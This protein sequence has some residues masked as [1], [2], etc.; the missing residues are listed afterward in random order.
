MNTQNE[1]SSNV[2]REHKDRLFKFIFGKP[3]NKKW[4]LSLYNAVN[5]SSYEN[6][7]D[8]VYTTIEDAVY[9]NMKN[10]VSFLI[11]DEMNFYEQQSTFNPNMPMR[12]FIYAGMVYSKYIESSKEY[13]KYSSKLQKAPTPKCICFY[14]GTAEQEDRTVLKLSD[15]FDSES[16]I[17]VLVTMINVNYGHNKELL[18][19]CKPLK[20]YSYFIDRIRFHQ[21][22]FETIEEAVDKALGDMPEDSLLKPFLIAN[23]AEVKRMFITEYDEA[24]T[25]SETMEEGLEKGREEGLVS[26]FAGLV[27]DGLLSLA[28]AAKRANMSEAEFIEKSGLNA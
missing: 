17:E 7:D 14:N 13:R 12:F 18:E 24:R 20:E 4:T 5:G 6:A 10:D 9:M 26:A 27:K 2:N 22:D 28:D 16:D 1:N 11:S 19:A 3:E 21:K 25:L 15:A 8:I 23:K